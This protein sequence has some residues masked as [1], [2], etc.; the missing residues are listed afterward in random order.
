MARQCNLV[1]RDPHQPV[2]SRAQIPK[3]YVC[4]AATVIHDLTQ[5]VQDQTL[6]LDGYNKDIDYGK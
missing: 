4:L 3:G 5:Q 2:I 1:K 6:Q